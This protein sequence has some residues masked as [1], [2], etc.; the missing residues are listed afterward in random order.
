MENNLENY[1]KYET[2]VPFLQFNYRQYSDKATIIGLVF[3]QSTEEIDR[4]LFFQ[5]W[6]YHCFEPHKK[7]AIDNFVIQ[8]KEVEPNETKK[9]LKKYYQKL[10]GWEEQ[11]K[12]IAELIFTRIVN[13]YTIYIKDI[14][15]QALYRAELEKKHNKK[16]DLSSY[17]K[18]KA[19]YKDYLNAPLYT[20]PE[21]ENLA[22]QI[23]TIRNLIVHSLSYI[24]DNY[25]TK[26][27]NWKDLECIK[28]D[29][30]I[31]YIQLDFSSWAN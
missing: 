27:H 29:A 9:S 6:V 21:D 28:Q 26:F 13:W 30:D 12:I 18:V 24:P 7:W 4:F 17:S 22:G 5:R 11:E 8:N 20:Q 2:T 23:L 31:L 1:F 19:F 3:A 14:A 16:F 10:F 15:G 25:V